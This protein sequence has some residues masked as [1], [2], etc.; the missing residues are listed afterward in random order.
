MVQNQIVAGMITR[1]G[2]LNQTEDHLGIDGVRGSWNGCVLTAMW[3]PE[4]R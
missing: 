3:G 4:D 2:H 1:V